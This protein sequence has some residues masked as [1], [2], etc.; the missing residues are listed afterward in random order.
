MQEKKWEIL[1]KQITKGKL[2]IA[3]IT[4]ILLKNRGLKSKKE[5]T[6]F[7]DPDLSDVTVDSV[8]IDTKQL[9]IALKRI[10]KAIEK[11]QRVIIFGDYDVD[12]ICGTAILWETLFT[13]NPN[14]MPYIP[15]R[16]DEGY[17]LSLKGI[18][19][20]KE[21]YP[22]VKL[23]ITV[24][25][26]IVAHKAVD[27][28]NKAA[29]DVIITDH[30]VV[31]SGGPKKLPKALAIVHTTKLCGTG[32]AYVLSQQLKRKNNES[33]NNEHAHLE[34]VAL[35]TI[36]DLVVL[37]GANR[38]LT[39]KG[40]EML[41]NTKRIGLIELF[42]EAVLTPSE[43]TAYHV[44]HVISPRLNAMGR[45]E[46]AMESLR[47]LCTKDLIRAQELAQKLGAT[48]KERQV[49]TQE[50]VLHA[51]SWVEE[52]NLQTEK[53][54][55]VAHESYQPGVIGLVAGK[56]V[57]AY[58]RPSI[59][60]AIGETH[61]KASARSI[62]G[63]NIIEFIRSASEHLVDA[64]GHPMAAGF[65]VEVTKITQLQE[66]LTKKAQTLLTDDM[67]L[68]TIKIDCEI[69]FSLITNDFFEEL[70]KFS[71]FGMGNAEP[72]FISR[73]V[74]VLD[75][76]LIGKDQKHVKF[77]LSQ[78]GKTFDAVAFSMAEQTIGMKNGDQIDIVYTIDEN[79]WNGKKSLQLKIRDMQ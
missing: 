13:Y 32:V 38:V 58:Y 14:A 10:A 35:A 74:T 51:K 45:L 36:A 1:S 63:F 70:K 71:P 44:G 16:I 68:R 29:I 77:K 15:H 30:H 62:S 53:L 73:D 49:V 46:S 28:A 52:N 22:D 57:E 39:K 11:K 26:G 21:L 42:K 17:G 20:V 55:F 9:L 78:D 72:V 43:I 4:K 56:L 76:R 75:K 67:F 31:P 3:D 5:I 19:Q 27:Y 66:F 54:L 34:L 40:L 47:L 61:A 41:A 65:T 69:P 37:L 18:D 48:N 25:N 60:L 33:E 6:A 64:G 12:G 50:T 59:V 8:E 2:Q 24:D 79:T 23:I 7:L